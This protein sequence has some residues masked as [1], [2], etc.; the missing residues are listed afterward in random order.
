MQCTY[1]P[2]S[3]AT[4][5]SKSAVFVLTVLSSPFSHPCVIGCLWFAS[6][7]AQYIFAVAAS[8]LCVPAGVKPKHYVLKTGNHNYVGTHGRTKNEVDTLHSIP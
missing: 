5:P 4:H 7:F 3:A 8:M 6:M 2:G 1:A